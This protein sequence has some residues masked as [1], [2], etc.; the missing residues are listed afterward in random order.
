MKVQRDVFMLGRGFWSFGSWHYAGWDEAFST[1][2][3]AQASISGV[4]WV[5][6]D[7]R[8]VWR[9]EQHDVIKR[10]E[11]HHAPKVSTRRQKD[12]EKADAA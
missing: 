10:I 6:D 9:T 1:L 5:K 4:T 3:T 8:R 12:A 7:K 11:L 2:E